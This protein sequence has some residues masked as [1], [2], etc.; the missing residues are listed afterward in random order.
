MLFQE[1]GSNGKPVLPVVIIRIN[2]SERRVY[3]LCSTKN[4]MS[5]SPGLLSYQ[6]LFTVEVRYVRHIGYFLISISDFHT[7]RLAKLHNPIAD[8]GSE[9]YLYIMPDDEDNLIKSG[10]YRI[11]DTIVDD[12]MAMVINRGQLF[13]CNSQTI[14]LNSR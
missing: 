10:G 11:V 12:K 14:R 13:D 5:G 7:Q 4:S 3:V 2:H 9:V 1:A 8:H 6:L